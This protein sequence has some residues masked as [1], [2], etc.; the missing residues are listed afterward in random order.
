MTDEHDDDAPAPVTGEETGLTC[1]RDG[2][3]LIETRY[4]A[5]VEV[6]QCPTC[7]GIFLDEGELRR[8]QDAVERDYRREKNEAPEHTARAYDAAVARSEAALPCPDCGGEMEREEYAHT[9]QVYIDV[10]PECR[11]VWLDA[12]ELEAIEVFVER[13]RSEAPLRI[14]WWVRLS[15]MLRRRPGR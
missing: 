13:G 7:R 4:E 6:D 8:I 2:A 15:L 10:C 12:G 14:P 11:G 5:D 3:H 1:P 9:S